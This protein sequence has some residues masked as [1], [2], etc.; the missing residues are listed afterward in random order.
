MGVGI[1]NAFSPLGLIDVVV[2]LAVAGL[3]YTISKFVKNIWVNI[4]QYSI[5]AGVLVAWE[6]LLVFNIPF[7]F[8]LVSVTASTLIMTAAGVVLVEA[9]MK[10]KVFN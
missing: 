1:A 6:L 7:M 9:L 5:I 4:I 3:A 2:G 8:S 10:R